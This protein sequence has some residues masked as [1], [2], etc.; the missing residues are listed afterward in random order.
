MENI[1]IGGT[2]FTAFES[3]G[4]NYLCTGAVTGELIFEFSG[5]VADYCSVKG[6]TSVVARRGK[7]VDEL[8]K[9]WLEQTKFYREVMGITF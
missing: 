2:K 7:T 6:A 4:V 1:I 9:E 3:D 8:Y 5:E